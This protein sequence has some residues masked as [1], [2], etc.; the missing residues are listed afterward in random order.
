MGKIGPIIYITLEGIFGDVVSS[1]LMWIGIVVV[2]IIVLVGIVKL[3]VLA[4]KKMMEMKKQR[5][6]TKSKIE[7]INDIS[8]LVCGIGECLW[9]VMGDQKQ[10]GG[11]PMNFAF[12]VGQLLGMDKSIAISSIGNDKNG[13][14]IVEE[15]NKIGL[16]HILAINN[17]HK[18]GVVNV[19]L[20]KG[21]PNYE[22]VKDVAW[23]YIPFSSEIKKKASNARAVCFG[24]LSQRS[25]ASRSCINSFIDATPDSCM[26][27][28]DI[29]LRQNYYT[30]DIVDSSMHRCNVMKLNN[31]EL[32][33]VCKMFGIEKN[34]PEDCCREI[35]S[36]WGI[37]T[38]IYTCGAEGSYIFTQDEMSYKDTPKVNVVDTVGA[39]DS[40]TAAFCA[41][42]LK[43]LPLDKAHQLAVDVSA[44]VCTRQGAM[45]ELPEKIR[46]SLMNN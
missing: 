6:E 12:H 16:R 34:T 4:N 32:P 30:K 5:K 29:N 39:G 17:S 28:F 10:L 40:F 14:N 3:I 20:H 44:Y 1:I 35:M 13:D 31:E 21:I 23:D 42:I 11:A 37:N 46:G 8:P 43:G 25:I 24:T 2:G 7:R 9:D 41:A 18:T 15:Y 26:R 19:K 27:I 36:S 22:I 38:I 45:P 33:I